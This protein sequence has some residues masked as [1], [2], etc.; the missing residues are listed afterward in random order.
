MEIV[1]RVRK[2]DLEFMKLELELLDKR[3]E[4]LESKGVLEVINESNK[5]MRVDRMK[6]LVK[7]RGKEILEM[8]KHF[9]DF[10]DREITLVSLN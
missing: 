4:F 9:E 10:P 3:V 8:E 6:E 5:T 7:I 2:Q 1:K